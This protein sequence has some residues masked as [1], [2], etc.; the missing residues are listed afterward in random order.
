MQNNRSFTENY[1]V[2]NKLNSEIVQNSTRV[3]GVKL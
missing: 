2:Y 1:E 3:E